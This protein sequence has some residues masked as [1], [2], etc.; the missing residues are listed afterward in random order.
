MFE[1]SEQSCSTQLS[2]LLPHEQRVIA[3]LQHRFP[4]PGRPSLPPS[5]VIRDASTV[6]LSFNVMPGRFVTETFHSTEYRAWPGY[7]EADF[8][9]SYK[10]QMAKSPATSSL[11]PPRLT[12]KKWPTSH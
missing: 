4:V 3:L 9:R 12:P 1:D 10:S 5:S 2:S 8:Y 7:V 11:R 6:E